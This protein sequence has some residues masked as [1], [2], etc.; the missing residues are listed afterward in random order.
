MAIHLNKPYKISPL[1]YKKYE[2]HY[3]IPPDRVL[4]V[5]LR[6]LGEEFSCDIRWEDEGGELKVLHNKIFIGANLVPLNAYLDEK[7]H[8]LWQHYYPEPIAQ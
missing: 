2:A 5:P 7:L 6:S 8:E 1:R 4:I 3:A